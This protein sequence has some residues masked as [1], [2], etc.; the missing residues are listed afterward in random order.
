MNVLQ[1]YVREADLFRDRLLEREPASARLGG[2]TTAR[3]N[4]PGKLISMVE[5]KILKYM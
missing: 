1:A 2:R 5:V 3:G 4:Q